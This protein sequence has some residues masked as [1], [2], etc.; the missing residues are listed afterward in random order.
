[1]AGDTDRRPDRVV[2]VGEIRG[3]FGVQG[4]VKL[5]SFTDPRE[6]LLKYRTF[7]TPD[8]RILKLV[9]GR[10]QGKT[11]VGK[12]DGVGDRDAA[13]ALH[14]TRLAVS[15]ADMPELEADEF[16]WSDIIGATVETANG[17]ELGVVDHL[18]ETGAHDVLVIRD[19]SQQEVL[20][21]FV[22]GTTVRSVDLEAGLIV[23]DWEGI[24]DDGDSD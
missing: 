4:W 23:V 11:L 7:A 8:G 19:S 3:A 13:L 1:M 12:L 20:V 9:E 15:R 5:F 21:P 17:E 6:N 24:A 16:Y 2:T 10:R 14:G 22:V 18:L